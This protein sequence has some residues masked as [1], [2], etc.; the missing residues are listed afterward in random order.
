MSASEWPFSDPPNVAVFTSR[1]I[2]GGIEWIAYVFH[3][4]DEGAWEFH[5]LTATRPGDAIVVG[6]GEIVELDPTV[7]ALAELPLG[8]SAR[9][10]TQH[11]A[12]EVRSSD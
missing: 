12:W 5:G 7:L 2:A 1:A 8:W 6:L 4:A 9:R 3:D 10:R 11:A